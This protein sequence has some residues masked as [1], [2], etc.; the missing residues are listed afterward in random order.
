MTANIAV[1]IRQRSIRQSPKDELAI[2]ASIRRRVEPLCRSLWAAVQRGGVGL[3]AVDKGHRIIRFQGEGD[4]AHQ[5]AGRKL[6]LDVPDDTFAVDL[7]VEERADT[8]LG[9]DFLWRDLHFDFGPIGAVALTRNVLS[10]V[11]AQPEIVLG[12]RPGYTRDQ[13]RAADQPADESH[14]NTHALLQPP[15]RMRIL[16]HPTPR[17]IARRHK[18]TNALKIT[19]E[20]RN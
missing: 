15:A 4:V 8:D 16:A 17:A 14:R 13:S 7:G 12:L 18:T 6:A 9:L 3:V 10:V 5:G 20:G 11:P 19:Q 1:A 2:L